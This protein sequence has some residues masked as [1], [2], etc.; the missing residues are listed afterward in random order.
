MTDDIYEHII[1]DGRRA[2]TIAAVEPQLKDRTVT[3]NGVSKTYAMTGFRIGYCGGPSLMMAEMLKMQSQSTSGP[4]SVGQAAALPQ[5]HV[6]A[7]Q[8]RV[9]SHLRPYG[10]AH[11]DGQTDRTRGLERDREPL[12]IDHHL[13]AE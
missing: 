8:R 12:Q 10:E 13:Q 1:F 9:L 5:L 2:A 11:P 7:E 6:V 3:I 4:S